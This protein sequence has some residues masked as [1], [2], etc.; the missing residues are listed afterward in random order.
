MNK[1][2]A[3]FV[4]RDGVINPTIDHGRDIEVGGKMVN[5]TA[6]FSYAQFKMF[7]GVAAALQAIRDMGFL[8]I[9]VTNQP[10]VAYGT[11]SQE[12]Y[13]KIMADVAKLPLD[14]IY[15]CPH[16]RNDVCECR[17]PKP[18]M[19]LKAAA[20]H[21]IN[22][23]VSYMVGDTG[24]D[25]GAAKAAGVIPILV[26]TPHN[27]AFNAVFRVKDLAGVAE[28]IQRMENIG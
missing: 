26:D 13:D 8:T 9:L 25:V 3:V 5:H 24:S 11:L 20:K 6:P 10:D 27:K 19:L 16:T 28:F 22:L 23:A 1:V 4:D 12:D 18:G 2:R 7:P 15:V 14:D 17:K 21:D